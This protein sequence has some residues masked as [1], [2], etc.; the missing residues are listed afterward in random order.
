MIIVDS[1]AL[2]CVLQEELDAD[3]ITALLLAET[4]NL[5]ISAATYLETATVIDANGNAVLSD[6]LDRMI[7][8]LEIEMVAVTAD[9]AR[10]ARQA[11]RTFGRGYHAAKLNFGDCFAYALAK[12]IGGRLLFKGDDFRKTDIAPAL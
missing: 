6:K 1:S 2:I 9:H 12:G 8:Y 11:Y 4:G 7:D 10:T 5:C 3:R